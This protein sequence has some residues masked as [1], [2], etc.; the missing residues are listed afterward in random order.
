VPWLPATLQSADAALLVVD[1]GEP[2][3]VDQL[4]ASV[5]CTSAS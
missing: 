1:L 2:A 3:C 5:A 4:A